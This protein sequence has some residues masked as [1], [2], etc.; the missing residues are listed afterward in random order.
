MHKQISYPWTWY[1]RTS[2]ILSAFW[3][4]FSSSYTWL[5]S[6]TIEKVHWNEIRKRTDRCTLWFYMRNRYFKIVLGW[7]RYIIF[8]SKLTKPQKALNKNYFACLSFNFTSDIVF[9]VSI[10]KDF[11]ICTC[12]HLIVSVFDRV[13][14]IM[15]IS[16]NFLVTSYS[17]CFISLKIE[18]N[19]ILP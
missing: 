7:L 6:L 16:P 19:I 13:N 4:S 17:C 8:L 18:Y 14:N 10:K 3:Y 5:L 1:V 2:S 12:N 11:T 9:I 15:F